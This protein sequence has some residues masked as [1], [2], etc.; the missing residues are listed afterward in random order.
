M[1]APEFGSP[2]WL[3]LK[4]CQDLVQKAQSPEV[5]GKLRMAGLVRHL[6]VGDHALVVRGLSAGDE[7]PTFWFREPPDADEWTNADGFDASRRVFSTG[8][9]RR[10]D[11]ATFLGARVAYFGQWY[12]V[13]QLVVALDHFYGG[14]AS[15][16]L[17]GVARPSMIALDAAVKREPNRVAVAVQEVAGVTL[18]ALMPLAENLPRKEAPAAVPEAVGSTILACPVMSRLGGSS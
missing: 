12:S 4:T 2:R 9:V 6:L 17:D 10:T 3:L 11:V 15:S 7:A 1:S 13:G 18:R 16:G 5:Y 14:G 8:E